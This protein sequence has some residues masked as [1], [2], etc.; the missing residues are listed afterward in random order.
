[1]KSSQSVRLDPAYAYPGIQA[2]QATADQVGDRP[3]EALAKSGALAGVSVEECNE[4]LLFMQSQ[5]K[6]AL[7]VLP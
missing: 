1:V 7:T 4:R 3:V 2:R 6:N 5:A